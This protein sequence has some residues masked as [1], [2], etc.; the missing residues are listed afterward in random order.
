MHSREIETRNKS[1]FVQTQ[2]EHLIY[3]LRKIIGR[4]NRRVIKHAVKYRFVLKGTKLCYSMASNRLIF[5]CLAL[6]M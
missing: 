5:M 1:L 4:T 6:Y 2:F 3:L